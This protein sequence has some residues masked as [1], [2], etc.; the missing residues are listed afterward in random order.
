VGGECHRG[1]HNST[2]NKRETLTGGPC[3][4]ASERKREGVRAVRLAERA[5]R[6]LGE[7]RG[8]GGKARPA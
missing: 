8:A 3:C 5:A 1:V 4:I 2:G 7:E 6:A